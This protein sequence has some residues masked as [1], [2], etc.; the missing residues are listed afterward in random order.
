MLSK[1]II[2]INKVKFQ[3]NKRVV[4]EM[5]KSDSIISKEE[6]ISEKLYK[7]LNLDAIISDNILVIIPIKQELITDTKFYPMKNYLQKQVFEVY[8]EEYWEE[9][10]IE[11][12]YSLIIHS[13][14]D[15][16]YTYQIQL[17]ADSPVG[18]GCFDV[19]MSVFPTE[20]EVQS[21]KFVARKGV[22]KSILKFK[23][24]FFDE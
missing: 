24:P 3:K 20:A 2:F 15:H 17:L 5:G 7:F 18:S 4:Q 16:S 11:G 22:Q 21:L 9:D 10:F 13:N 8:R 6:N 1:I 14:Y 23:N 12:K 19:Y